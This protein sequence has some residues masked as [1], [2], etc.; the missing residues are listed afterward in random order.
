MR[1][2]LDRYADTQARIDGVSCICRLLEQCGEI[3]RSAECSETDPLP[4]DGEFNLVN[5]R[6]AAHDVQV[7]P[8]EFGLQD[9]VAIQRKVKE[10]PDAA[11]GP[12]RHAFDVLV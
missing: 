6:K 4:V 9:V 7:G 3:L 12:E 8:E 11:D 5:G 2:G 10:H 1:A